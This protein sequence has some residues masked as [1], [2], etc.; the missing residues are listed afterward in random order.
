VRYGDDRNNCGGVNLQFD[1]GRGTA[2]RLAQLGVT[3][4]HLDAIFFTHM[5]SDHTDGF[6]DIMQLRWHFE[7]ARP[8]L[9]VVC[10]ADT[11]SALGFTISCKRLALH[12]GDA[13]IESG[14]I[15]Q[16]VSDDKARPAGGPATVGDCI[17]AVHAWAAW[18]QCPPSNS[19]SAF[20]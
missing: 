7:Y 19:A 6:A 13:Y 20:L 5:H 17:E 2:V 4:G 12:I 16:R 11:V 3:V 18:V 14:E 8:K 10:S 9:D 15:A 1:A